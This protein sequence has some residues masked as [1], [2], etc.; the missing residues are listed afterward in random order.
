M[1]TEGQFCAWVTTE[2]I[3]SETISVMK[4]DINEFLRPHGDDADGALGQDSTAAPFGDAIEERET[5]TPTD[6]D[7]G[8]AAT[9]E[10]NGNPEYVAEVDE[11]K[12]CLGFL[13]ED[14]NQSGVENNSKPKNSA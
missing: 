1:E 11:N 14:N 6:D 9:E 13:N 3:D 7:G 4:V 5:T 10:E 12:P 8:D 2:L